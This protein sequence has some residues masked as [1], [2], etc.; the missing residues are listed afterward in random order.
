VGERVWRSQARSPLGEDGIRHRGTDGSMGNKTTRPFN[1]SELLTTRNP[2]LSITLSVFGVS[3]AVFWSFASVFPNS[4]YYFVDITF[5]TAFYSQ[6]FGRALL[7][8]IGGL[9]IL[10]PIALIIWWY[11]LVVFRK[12]RFRKIAKS[13]SYHDSNLRIM[14]FSICIILAFWGTLSWVIYVPLILILLLRILYSFITHRSIQRDAHHSEQTMRRIAVIDERL[15]HISEED[16]KNGVV[17][18]LKREIMQIRNYYSLPGS[19]YLRRKFRAKKNG[20]DM[21]A[22]LSI[23]GIFGLAVFCGLGYALQFKFS[24][25]TVFLSDYDK[26][27]VMIGRSADYLILYDQISNTVSAHSLNG[28]H[29]IVLTDLGDRN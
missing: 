13:L 25:K 24:E 6:I 8:Y 19:K 22:M 14:L 17:D 10:G 12:L 2:Y 27:G 21:R 18:D 20:P 9:A 28:I 11:P 3:Q 16:I 7:G 23:S 15:A 29:T 26:S 5:I 4:F 1:L